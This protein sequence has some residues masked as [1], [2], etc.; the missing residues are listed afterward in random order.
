MAVVVTKKSFILH[1]NPRMGSRIRIRAVADRR[2]SAS[3]HLPSCPCPCPY[4]C[5]S[6]SNPKEIYFYGLIWV[7][8]GAL[9]PEI[10]RHACYWSARTYQLRPWYCKSAQM[11]D[12][13]A[14]PNANPVYVHE[15]CTRLEP[16]GTKLTGIHLACSNVVGKCLGELTSLLY[17]ITDTQF[18]QAQRIPYERRGRCE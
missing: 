13:G 14:S 10:S 6:I 16:H 17:E 9:Y 1:L 2:T 3:Y 18:L 15:R 7:Q 4:V 11:V 5:L 8:G 12:N